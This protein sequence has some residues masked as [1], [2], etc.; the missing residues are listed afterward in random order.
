MYQDAKL[1]EHAHRPPLDDEQVYIYNQLQRRA[2]YLKAENDTLS[3]SGFLFTA[4]GV[5]TGT[6]KKE[7]KKQLVLGRVLFA[8]FYYSPG[9]RSLR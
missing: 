2:T 3:L 8:V 6:K 7:R 1:T 9:H 5:H 4:A